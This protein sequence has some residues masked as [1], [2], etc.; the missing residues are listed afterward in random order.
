MTP[1]ST[2]QPPTHC[3]SPA[4]RMRA[5]MCATRVSFTWLGTR[6]TLSTAQKA[7]AAESFGAEGEF[8][9]AGKKLL[10]T[11]H[12]RFKAVTSVRNRTRSYWTSLSLPYPE[13]EEHGPYV[14]DWDELEAQRHE[15]GTRRPRYEPAVA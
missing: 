7:L 4:N 1:T 3:T 9:S 14:I 13:P 6:K 2:T 10:D 5:T 15:T 11:K 8:L 12:A